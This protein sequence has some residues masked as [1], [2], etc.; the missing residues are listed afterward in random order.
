MFRGHSLGWVFGTTRPIA[1]VNYSPAVDVSMSPSVCIIMG[2]KSDMPV[3]EKAI[4]VLTELRVPYTVTVASAHRTP[5]R[6]KGI[7]KDSEAHVFIAP[8][9]IGGTAARSPIAGEGID[10]MPQAFTFVDPHVQQLGSDIYFHG[11][12]QRD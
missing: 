8:K 1:R 7:V 12:L 4:K 9:L 11:R 2:S 6:V 10:E 5:D 3:A